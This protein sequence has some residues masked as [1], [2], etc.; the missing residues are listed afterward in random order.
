MPED[1]SYE[2][3]SPRGPCSPSD[4]IPASPEPWAGYKRDWQPFARLVPISR[5][6]RLAFESAI[7]VIKHEPHHYAHVRRNMF[8]EPARDESIS[9]ASTFTDSENAEAQGQHD[10]PP[11]RYNGHFCFRLDNPPRVPRTGWV[12]G[13]GR[14]SAATKVDFLLSAPRQVKDIAGKHAVIFLHPRSCRLVLGPRHRASTTMQARSEGDASLTS[15]TSVVP[16]ELGV[17]EQIRIGDCV[18]LFEYLG[19]ANCETHEQQL[20]EFMKQTHGQNWEGVLKLLSSTP[21]ASLMR[22][23]NYT[24]PLGAFAKGT[25]GQVT[26]GTESKGDP[27]AIK[28]LHAPQEGQL[29]AHRRMMSHI[30]KHVRVMWIL[31]M[32]A[33]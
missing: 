13:D 16:A 20:A 22:L 4:T 14:S 32:L 10:R 12:L 31:L 28:R 15:P 11:Y 26:A 1:P 8:I 21:D 27:V 33:D 17:Q 19:F 7:D 18:Y 5:A 24:W 9:V 30:G 23:H 3:G 25:F 29:S 2:L 6:A